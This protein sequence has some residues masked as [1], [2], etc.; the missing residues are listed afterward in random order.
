MIHEQIVRLE[1][2]KTE[3]LAEIDAI[4][5]DAC[6]L[7]RETRPDPTVRLIRRYKAAAQ[8]E[9]DKAKAELDGSRHEP[10]RRPE[11]RPKSPA[12]PC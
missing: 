8:R 5:H 2:F 6:A 4:D 3:D 11:K 9:M 10:P 1:R 12:R 7:G